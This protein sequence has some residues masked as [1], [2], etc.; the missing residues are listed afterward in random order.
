MKKAPPAMIWQEVLSSFKMQPFISG[1]VGPV[2]A[3]MDTVK[4]YAEERFYG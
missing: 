3:I 1:P 4:S 2:S